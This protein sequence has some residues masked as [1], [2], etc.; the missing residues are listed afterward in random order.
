MLED[1]ENGRT[2][3]EMRNRFTINDTLEL[4]SKQNNNAI[5]NL[6]KIEDEEGNELEVCKVP[7]QIVYIYTN[8]K[9]NKNEILR[10]KKSEEL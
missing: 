9:L 7:K 1:S 3:V 4:L 10:R 2:K 6:T 8:I 5:I